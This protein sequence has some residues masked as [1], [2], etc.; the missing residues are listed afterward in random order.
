M[1]RRVYLLIVELDLGVFLWLDGLN[2]LIK[3]HLLVLS[4]CVAGDAA[5]EV[6][7]LIE[8]IRALDRLPAEVAL[9]DRST[10]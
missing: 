8:V 7:V 6:A 2:K 3:T 1:E 5:V 4:A 10:G 9:A